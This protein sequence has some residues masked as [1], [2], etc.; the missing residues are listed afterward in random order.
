MTDQSPQMPDFV[1]DGA[2]ILDEL[3]ELRREIHMD[4]ELGLDLPRT[5]ERVTKALEDL[6]LEI[7]L[8]EDLSSVTAVL[9]G[10]KPGPTVLL[11]GDMDALPVKEETGLP[12]AATG[13]TM[14]A[15][16][17]DMHTAGLV[18]AAKILS[19][20]RDE[21]A[22]NVI[23]MFQP[24]EEGYGG[25]KIMIDEGVLDVTGDRPIG[26]YAIHVAPGPRGVLATRHG[27]AAA[28][29]NRVTAVIKGRGGH[30]SQPHLAIDPVPAAAE[31][32]SAIQ[33]FVTRKMDAFDPVVVTVTQV[34]T[35]D[36]AINVIPEKVSLGM[37]VRT[38]TPQSLTRI[39]EG[40]ESVIQATAA[41]HECQAEVNFQVLYPSTIND[42]AATDMAVADV[43]STLGGNRVHIAPSPMMGSE[44][45]AFV[46][47][48]V[49]GTFFGMFVTPPEMAGEK[50][51][52]NHSPR[53]VADDAILG[54]QS[55]ALASMAFGRLARAEREAAAK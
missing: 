22:G 6:P 16:G 35:G 10:G 31:A 32:I 4:P 45:F 53:F 39:S 7:T 46:L 40:L 24:G 36:N 2:E 43:R 23:F 8:G 41:A 18:G 21:I 29:S 49:P 37:T 1:G 50:A 25:A 11:R 20:H 27:S 19:K 34:S 9:R 54:D 3:V 48:E 51:E 12:Y 14:H 5:Q 44:D 42:P 38:L 17:H 33:A 30:G 28:G 26:A 15:C 55:A 13:D 52:F 47:D